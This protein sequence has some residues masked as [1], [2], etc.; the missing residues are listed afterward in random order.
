MAAKHSKQIDCGAMN[1]KFGYSFWL[2]ATERSASG[3]RPRRT[4]SMGGYS[5]PI[6]AIERSMQSY[7]EESDE[8]CKRG[9]SLL[10]ETISRY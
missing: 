7:L 4:I 5:A 3:K 2:A 1:L 10:E 8:R 6:D 9:D